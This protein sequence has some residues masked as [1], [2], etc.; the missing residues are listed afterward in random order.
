MKRIIY[1]FIL[2]LF[3]LQQALAANRWQ[4]GIQ[5]EPL[6]QV[7][8]TTREINAADDAIIEDVIKSKQAPQAEKVQ[9]ISQ[10]TRYGFKSPS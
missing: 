1:I 5:Q 4:N 6:S 7:E 2:S 9:Y 10:Q 8:D 3:V